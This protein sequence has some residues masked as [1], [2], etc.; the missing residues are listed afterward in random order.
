GAMDTL[1]RSLL[2]AH[3]M[4]EDR[5]LDAVLEARY[6]GWDGE[7]GRAIAAGEHSLDSLHALVVEQDLRPTPVSG[8]QEALENLVNRYI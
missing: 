1:A 6:A 8:R 3:A 5:A 2:V 4:L 7:L